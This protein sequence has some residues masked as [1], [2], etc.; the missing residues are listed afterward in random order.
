VSRLTV[1]LVGDGGQLGKTLQSDWAA[2]DPSDFKLHPFSRAELDICSAEQLAQR[3]DPLNI[4]LVVNAAAYTQVDK[5]ESEPDQAMAINR[6]GVA[7]LAQWVA[8]RGSRLIH[9]S[10]DFVFDGLTAR[11]RQPSDHTSPL[12][13][14]GQS[15]LAGE[16]AVQANCPDRA[17]ILR[18]GWL[19]S[20][21]QPNFVTTM[22][23]LMSER[24]RL[25]VVSDQVGTPTSTHSL[26]RLIAR[27]ARDQKASGVFHWSDA[28]VASWYDFAVAVQEEALAAGLLQRA[29]PI[30]P[31]TTA[32]YPTPAVRPAYSVLDKSTSYQRFAMPAIHWREELRQVIAELKAAR[33]DGH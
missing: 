23:R 12:N 25:G 20:R 27:I 32:D 18:T 26:G 11:P 3:L 19:Y 14:Y 10:T 17:V 30:T 24:E 5:A 15:K 9:V 16:L 22:L 8:D 13:H 31:I 4:Q 21:H 29:I 1:A 28:G 2:S 33:Q 7:R 6:D